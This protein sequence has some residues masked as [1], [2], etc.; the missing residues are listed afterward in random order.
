LLFIL[1]LKRRE[2]HIF[3]HFSNEFLSPEGRLVVIG[4]EKGKIV[5]CV[6]ILKEDYRY[7]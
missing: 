5:E 6:E 3:M 2:K 7:N 1:H 4:E